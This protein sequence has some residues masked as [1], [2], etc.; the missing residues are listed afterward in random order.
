MVRPTVRGISKIQ[1]GGDSPSTAH[2][3]I[4]GIEVSESY[5]V[6]R[7]ISITTDH[8]TCSDDKCCHL[9]VGIIVANGA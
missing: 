1:E 9:N 5:P 8:M 3:H 2:Y 6:T 4:D 7:A